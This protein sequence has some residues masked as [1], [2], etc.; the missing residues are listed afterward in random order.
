[1][2]SFPFLFV[3]SGAAI[4]RV[5][6][7]LWHHHQLSY[8]ALANHVQTLEQQIAQQTQE[9]HLAKETADAANQAK[10][11]FLAR[12]SHELRTPLNAIIGFTHL[13]QHMSF[14]DPDYRNYLQIVDRSSEHLLTLINDILDL[15]K[16][17][18]GRI[19]LDPSDFDLYRLLTIVEDMLRLRSQAK[20]LIL[21]L[22]YTD[23]V[24]QYV[25]ADEK[26]LRQVLINLLGN[27]IKFTEQGQVKLMVKVVPDPNAPSLP[28]SPR[29]PGQLQDYLYLEFAVEDTGP[30]IASD[31]IDLVFEPFCQTGVGRNTME[32]TGLG[33]SI[34][35]KFVQLMDGKIELAST[36]GKGSTFSF[37]IPLEPIAP[38]EKPNT[39]HRPILGIQ[40]GSPQY[41]VLIVDDRRDNRLLLHKL[42]E[43]L[44]FELEEAVNGLETVA[45]WQSWHPHLIWMD[46]EMPNMNGCQAI[47][48]IRRQEAIQGKRESDP[49]TI[50]IALT[51]SVLEV[52]EAQIRTLGCDDFVQKPFLNHT[53]FE[54][55][56]KHLPI[57]YIYG[58][59]PLVDLERNSIPSDLSRFIARDLSP[60]DFSV[61]SS[62]WIQDLHQAALEGKD[63]LILQLIEQIPQTSREVALTLLAWT[64]DFRFDKITALTQALLP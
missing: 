8:Q 55:M 45:L 64:Q 44:G 10:S 49:H 42:L 48:E 2:L 63:H 52:Q 14:P 20:S 27:S 11:E 34:S 53:I 31:Q 29:K 38:L 46:L 61:M 15:S 28:F 5:G 18:A 43:P 17:E 9:L 26:K 21:A 30:G 7:L 39:N 59:P 40:P 19:T 62:T 36:E 47:T 23:Q 6:G 24:P 32:G 16:I 54:T 3:F 1:M 58:D 22:T 33:L 37:V 4:L 12:M 35:Q 60:Q 50:I 56:G 51:A 41:R 25:R 13:L 57:Q